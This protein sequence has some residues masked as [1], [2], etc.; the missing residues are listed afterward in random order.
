MCEAGHRAIR[1]PLFRQAPDPGERSPGSKELRWLP[2]IPQ[3]ADLR[4][5]NSL[6]RGK[7]RDQKG[8]PLVPDY[9]FTGG[10]PAFTEEGFSRRPPGSL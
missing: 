2:V 5:L 4:A 7:S 8:Y 1:A 3:T 6:R 9:Y 10:P